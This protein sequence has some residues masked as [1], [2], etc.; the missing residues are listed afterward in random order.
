MMDMAAVSIASGKLLRSPVQK[1]P[2][3]RRK[4]AASWIEQRHGRR[5]W[6]RIGEQL[7]QCATRE[8]ALDVVRPRLARSRPEA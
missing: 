1:D 8:I 7:D 2:N 5:R 4:L 6:W 3:S